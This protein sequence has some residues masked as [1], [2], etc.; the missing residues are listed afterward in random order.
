MRH[1]LERAFFGQIKQLGE[2]KRNHFVVFKLLMIFWLLASCE[3]ESLG[4]S[5]DCIEGI[6]TERLYYRLAYES[7]YQ[8]S[9]WIEVLNRDGLGKDVEIFTPAPTGQPNSPILY[10]NVIEVPIP[11]GFLHNQSLEEAFGKKI[12][13]IYRNPD[14]QEIATIRNEDCNE[15]YRTF[16]VPVFVV[17]AYAL[18]QCP[19]DFQR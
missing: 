8:E 1:N 10:R 12:Y 16:S 11:S 3:N 5:T 9:I 4:P 18:D 17:T 19:N 14:P 13:F 15:V 2:M 7:C 6:V